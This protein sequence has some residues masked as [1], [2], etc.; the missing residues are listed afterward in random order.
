MCIL[1]PPTSTS[2]PG[3]GWE[4][5]SRARDKLWYK[6]PLKT[7][8]PKTISNTRA[9]VHSRCRKLLAARLSGLIF[10]VAFSALHSH[11][12]S[13]GYEIRRV[14]ME[15]IASEGGTDYQQLLTTV[16]RSFYPRCR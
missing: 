15:R 6:A 7:A 13:S 14:Y 16:A 11:V 5:R 4:R 2:W 3:M 8:L 10:I 9:T 12:L 1:N